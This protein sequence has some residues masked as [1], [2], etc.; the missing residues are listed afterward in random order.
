MKASFSKRDVF[1]DLL[2]LGEHQPV[3][4]NLCSIEGIKN[5][6]RSYQRINLLKRM[7]E[8]ISQQFF[9]IRKDKSG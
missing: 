1:I 2:N 5:K 9:K 8:E 4:E 7:L 3:N 6:T